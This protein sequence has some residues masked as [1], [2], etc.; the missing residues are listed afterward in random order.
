MDKATVNNSELMEKAEKI[1]NVA[2]VAI[3]LKCTVVFFGVLFRLLLL[4]SIYGLFIPVVGVLFMFLIAVT[5]IFVAFLWIVYFA[6]IAFAVLALIQ[7]VKLIEEGKKTAE[8]SLP[9]EAND[10]VTF[11][12]I[13]SII[14]LALLFVK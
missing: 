3:A 14:I 5:L 10:K 1:R 11:A 9:K 4:V 13:S 7:S 6:Y 8:G 2:I 12:M